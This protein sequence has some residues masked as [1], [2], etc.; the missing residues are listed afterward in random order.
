VDFLHTDVWVSMGEPKEV[1]DER[2]KLLKP[3]QVN[4]DVVKKT[5]NPQVKFMHCLPAFHN[6]E[7]KVGEEIY[8]KTAWMAGS[9]RRSLR[10]AAVDRLRPGREPHAHDQGDHGGD[11]G[12]FEIKPIR[13]LLDLGT[14][15]ICAGGGGIP[16]MYDEQQR[17]HG[18][19]AVIDKDLASAL[20]AEELEADLL[21][22]ATD[23][24][25]VYLDWGTPTQRRLG[26]VTPAEI[27]DLDL[28]AG[29]MG[30]KVQAAV[31]FV[32]HTGGRAAIGSLADIDQIVAG[33]A[34]T[35]VTRA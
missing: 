23:V 11:A 9:D 34:G 2:I 22:I 16:T 4:M 15:V 8:Q 5:G 28:P 6:R 32:E 26:A 14:I 13:Q 7:T 29:S 31:R 30:P 1:W 20:L 35:Q 3:Y 33:T 24:D 25:G 10:V 18:V 12:I 27:V 19:E 17:L 21:V